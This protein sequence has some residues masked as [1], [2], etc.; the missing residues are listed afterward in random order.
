MTPQDAIKI[1]D[2]YIK[3]PREGLPEDVFYFI[4]RNTPLINVD[5]LV[6]D[7][8]GR[9]LL[10]WRDDTYSGVGWHL[11]GGII[12]FKET[13]EARLKKV[14]ELE[15]GTSDITF[16]PNPLAINEI[17]NPEHE[18]RGHFISVLYKCSLPSAF[19]PDNKDLK[20]TDPGFLKW[21]E[22]CPSDLLKFHEIYRK[23]L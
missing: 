14:A 21:H 15:L 5:L 3:N 10:A 4:S 8:A 18:N 12:R 2:A 22:A 13:M 23:Y 1:L 16:D 20:E 6:K 7:E 17:F 9:A 19:V 11:V